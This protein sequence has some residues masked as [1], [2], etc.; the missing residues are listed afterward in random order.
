MWQVMFMPRGDTC[1]FCSE[2]V[3]LNQVTWP[4]LLQEIVG[5][6]GNDLGDQCRLQHKHLLKAYLVPGDILYSVAHVI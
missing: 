5:R 4:V 6:R 1:S 2:S 3:S